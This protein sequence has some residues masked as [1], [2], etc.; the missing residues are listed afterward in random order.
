MRMKR[1]AM[2]IGTV[3]LWPPSGMRPEPPW[4][5]ALRVVDTRTEHA[6]TPAYGSF[7]VG[8]TASAVV[9]EVIVRPPLANAFFRGDCWTYY[10][11]PWDLVDLVPEHA[12]IEV[13]W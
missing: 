10:V 1:G 7:C 6:L 4:P 9:C 12:W 2:P 3:F 13:V 8:D 11:L 5:T